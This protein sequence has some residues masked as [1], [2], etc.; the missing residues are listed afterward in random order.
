MSRLSAPACSIEPSAWPLPKQL[1]ESV[2]DF[3]HFQ[4]G[5]ELAYALELREIQEI[6][7]RHQKGQRPELL[8]V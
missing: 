2:M 4:D 1:L 6:G 3:R 8:R 7:G 5:R